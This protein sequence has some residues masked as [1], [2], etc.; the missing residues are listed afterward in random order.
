MIRNRRCSRLLGCGSWW[1]WWALGVFRGLPGGL[2]S[3]VP[4]NRTTY[5]GSWCQIW[6]VLTGSSPCRPSTCSAPWSSFSTAIRVSSA[7]NL[8]RFAVS[9]DCRVFSWSAPDYSTYHSAYFDLVY[10]LLHRRRVPQLPL[11]LAGHA[12]HH[13][14]C[15]HHRLNYYDLTISYINL[16]NN[17]IRHTAEA[18]LVDLSV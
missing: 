4:G 5:S 13:V 9:F 14:T 10:L 6:I 8:T 3:G 17:P 7:G 1:Q 11:A 12:E 15:I 18:L 2:S 16:I